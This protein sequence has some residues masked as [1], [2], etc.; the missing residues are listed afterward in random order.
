MSVRFDTSVALILIWAGLLIFMVMRPSSYSLSFWLLVG[1]AMLSGGL[2]SL[3]SHMES[4]RV[5]RATLAWLQQVNE[6]VDVRD[7]QDD[8]HLPEYLDESERRRVVEE[9]ERMPRGSRSLRRALGIV[10]PELVDDA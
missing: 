2:Y 3:T 4:K 8:G 10:S 6:L 5:K 7:F 1:S 9:L